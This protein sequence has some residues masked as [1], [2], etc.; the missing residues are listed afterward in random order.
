M[1]DS[2]CPSII[3]WPLSRSFPLQ[4]VGYLSFKKPIMPFG[5][6]EKRMV[7]QQKKVV[8]KPHKP[9]LSFRKPKTPKGKTYCVAGSLPLDEVL[10]HLADV[11][12]DENFIEIRV[13]GESLLKADLGGFVFILCCLY[14]FLVFWD[15]GNRGLSRFFFFVYKHF[16]PKISSLSTRE[17]LEICFFLWYDPEGPGL[18]WGFFCKAKDPRTAE[19]FLMVFRCFFCVLVS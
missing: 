14:F 10:P 16:S 19:S 9:P 5:N 15:G 6:Q 12:W 7:F 17:S 18:V 13:D 4:Q 2:G 1:V 3:S 8:S 11:E